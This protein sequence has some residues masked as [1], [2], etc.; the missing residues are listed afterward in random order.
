MSALKEM[1][2]VDL[3]KSGIQFLANT[4]L[5]RRD[6][7]KGRSSSFFYLTKK[8]IP[9]T[10]TYYE[11]KKDCINHARSVSPVLIRMSKGWYF[12]YPIDE[13]VKKNTN[14][15]K[16]LYE[17]KWVIANCSELMGS[18]LCK[19]GDTLQIIN[20]FKS[21]AMCNIELSEMKQRAYRKAH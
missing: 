17:K 1:Y 2:E 6:Q 10:T 15:K 4:E 16:N 12:S 3:R 20:T 19:E 13:R 18:S 5:K 14:C 9:V 8:K 11:T 7:N 21:K